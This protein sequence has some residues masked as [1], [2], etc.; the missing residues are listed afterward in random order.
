MLHLLSVDGAM[1]I[2]PELMGAVLKVVA[3][4]PAVGRLVMLKKP[5]P[6]L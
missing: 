2:L 4:G 5:P 1:M 6:I 3:G